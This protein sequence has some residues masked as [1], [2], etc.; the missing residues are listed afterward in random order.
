M[1]T[2]PIPW[3]D[4][5]ALEQHCF[6]QHWDVTPFMLSKLFT[7]NDLAEVRESSTG[8]GTTV[9]WFGSKHRDKH[10]ALAR[11]LF[12]VYHS[13]SNLATQQVMTGLQFLETVRQLE[14]RLGFRPPISLTTKSTSPS[15]G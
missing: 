1:T 3:E 8:K 11:H 2:P 10:P 12:P 5:E 14:V 15:Q 7:L 13:G 6:K 4:A 9:V